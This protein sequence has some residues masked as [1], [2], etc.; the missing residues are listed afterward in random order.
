[1]ALPYTHIV[2]SPDTGRQNHA[3]P[4]TREPPHKRAEVPDPS[5]DP[6]V[7]LA[8]SEIVPQRWTSRPFSLVDMSA[9]HKDAGNQQEVFRKQTCA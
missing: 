6:N 1:M 8:V 2:L 9:R 4:L 3:P 7:D 5:Y